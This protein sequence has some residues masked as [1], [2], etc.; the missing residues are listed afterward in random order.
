MPI[1]KSLQQAYIPSVNIEN[2]RTTTNT[3]VLTDE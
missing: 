3:E 1:D 2:V